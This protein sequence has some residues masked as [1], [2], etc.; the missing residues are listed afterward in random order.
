MVEKMARHEAVFMDI[1][2]SA[3][4]Q[5]FYLRYDYAADDMW[6]LTYGVK[7]KERS[8]QMTGSSQSIDMSQTRTGPQYRCP[9]C[10]NVGIV[11]CG[12]CGQLVCHDESDRFQ[13]ICGHRGV[14]TGRIRAVSG[15]TGKAQ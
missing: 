8:T 9:Y 14:I 5:K 12:A 2:C 7:E 1:T 3:Y 13:C 4:R 11:K 6:V 15:Y 10:G